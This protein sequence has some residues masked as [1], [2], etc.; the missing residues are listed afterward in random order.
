MKKYIIKRFALI[1]VSVGMFTTLSATTKRPTLSIKIPPSENNGNTTETDNDYSESSSDSD[2]LNGE[3]M[4]TPTINMYCMMLNNMNK[5]QQ[6]QYGNLNPSISNNTNNNSLNP[7]PTINDINAINNENI[8]NVFKNIKLTLLRTDIN[9]PLSNPLGTP[10][11]PSNRHNNNTQNRGSFPDISQA[12]T[13]NNK[14]NN[15]VYPPSKRS[16]QNSITCNNGNPASQAVKKV[17]TDTHDLLEDENNIKRTII[18]AVVFAFVLT[19]L[20][21]AVLVVTVVIYLLMPQKPHNLRVLRK[22]K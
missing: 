18:L 19:V 6:Q 13:S 1:A 2:N 12:N 17:F 16:L 15:S 8:Y 21:V 11:K 4:D 9:G 10:Q 3:N 20:V 5:N 7:L 22:R 14:N